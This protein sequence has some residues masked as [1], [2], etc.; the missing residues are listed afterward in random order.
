[1]SSGPDGGVSKSLI[2]ALVSFWLVSP[3]SADD[4]SLERSRVLRVMGSVRDLELNL[5]PAADGAGVIAR[6]PVAVPR[7]DSLRL[8]FELLGDEPPRDDWEVHLRQGDEIRWRFAAD[9]LVARAIWSDE[10]PG[11][12]VLVE[13]VSHVGANPVRI[14][15]DLVAA[16]R[17][18]PVPLSIV[19]S[20]ERTPIGM[21]DSWVQAIGRA[22]AR[23][24]FI[25]DDRKIYNCTG[26]LITDEV[27]LTNEHCISSE[28]ELRSALV[29]FDFDTR[30]AETTFTRLSELIA[31]DHDLDYA[32]VRLSAPLP[33]RGPLRFG[34][35]GVEADEALLI[36][37][38]P[39]GEPKQVSI[40]DCRVERV[41]VVGRG[42][43][44]TDFT[45]RCDTLGGSSGSPVIS[46]RTR[47]VVGL[48][49]LG[50]EDADA[51]LF[52][53]AVHIDRVRAHLPAELRSALAAMP[54]DPP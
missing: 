45:H 42:G 48:H 19:G 20:D 10:I 1:M 7:A 12:G 40:E 5:F 28:A 29:D 33:D 43:T 52:N 36:V 26:F 35:A 6:Q 8:H 15:I 21:H 51:E 47:Q 16:I 34:D 50:F 53:R 14:R 32:L 11:D 9:D 30:I 18:G 54:P 24:R 38:H 17:P 3:A 46:L 41:L 44:D 13:L 4:L 27:M 23:L 49:H 2:V 39:G 37:Q 31:H 25:G 22:V